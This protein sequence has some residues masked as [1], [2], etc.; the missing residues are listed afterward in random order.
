MLY[1]SADRSG[2]ENGKWEMGNVS[3]PKQ[4]IRAIYF[5]II[6]DTI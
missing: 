5:N 4:W 1:D 6:I 3:I 2:R